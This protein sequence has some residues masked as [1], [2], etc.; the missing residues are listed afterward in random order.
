MAFRNSAESPSTLAELAD[1]A[2]SL[3]IMGDDRAIEATYILGELA[4][5]TS[6]TN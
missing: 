1:R 5:S 3:V 4:H 2:F 6:N